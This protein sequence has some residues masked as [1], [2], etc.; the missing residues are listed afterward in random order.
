MDVR[1]FDN[2]FKIA[3]RIGIYAKNDSL[4]SIYT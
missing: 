2:G 4:V 1:S 3:I